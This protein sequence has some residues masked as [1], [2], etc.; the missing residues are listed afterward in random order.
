MHQDQKFLFCFDFDE[1]LT[2]EH[3]F[4]VEQLQDIGA[5][6]CAP[7]LKLFLDKAM[8][9]GHK[10][11]I[12]TKNT[13]AN[14]EAG[15]KLLGYDATNVIIVTDK[16][17]G[18]PDGNTYGKNR[19]IQR[20]LELA[21]GNYKPVLVD[22]DELNV[23]RAIEN[24]HGGVVVWRVQ[25][26]SPASRI[27]GRKPLL[28]EGAHIATLNSILQQPSQMPELCQAHTEQLERFDIETG[29]MKSPQ[30]FR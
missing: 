20:A 7:N 6:K 8:A 5:I 30:R 2:N 18:N 29:L 10:I 28:L 3:I 11:A 15:L 12:T 9:D 4:G 17:V 21:N 14:V 22:D 25:E 19:H 26:A 16:D 13:R 23:T 24:G 1:T 27:G